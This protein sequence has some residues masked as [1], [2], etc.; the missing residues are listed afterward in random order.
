MDKNKINPRARSI[1]TVLVKFDRFMT[2]AE[3]AD[4]ARVSW[5]TA[6]GYLKSFY[7]KGWVEKRGKKVLYWKAI[8]ED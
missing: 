3:V 7:R 1:L 8:Y 4:E 6:L 2:T 5:N